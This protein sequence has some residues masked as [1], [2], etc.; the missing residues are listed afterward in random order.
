MIIDLKIIEEDKI[1]LK[2]IEQKILE[3]KTIKQMIIEQKIIKIK[4]HNRI[5]DYMDKR[6]QNRK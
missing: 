6:S 2:I 5:E 3:Q 1:E 4:E